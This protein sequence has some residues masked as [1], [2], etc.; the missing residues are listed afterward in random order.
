[1]FRNFLLTG[2]VLILSGAILYTTLLNLDPLGQQKTIALFS[3]FI[4]VFFGVGAFCT[5]LFFFGAE[6]FRGR[7]LASK[8]FLVAIRRGILTSIFVIAIFVLQ[9]FR[10][11]GIL[12]LLLLAI[13]LVLV[14]LIFTSASKTN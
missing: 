10:F 3:F 4:S 6:L 11:V 8:A 1:M 9:Y 13:F 12:E 2:I 14:E 5:F 7:R